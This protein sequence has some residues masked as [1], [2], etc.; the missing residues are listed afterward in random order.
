MPATQTSV[1]E[2]RNAHARADALTTLGAF[3][4]L[5]GGCALAFEIEIDVG[6][7]FLRLEITCVSTTKFIPAHLR[8]Q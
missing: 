7:H 8:H 3:L 2:M 5:L 4:L 1:E 6:R